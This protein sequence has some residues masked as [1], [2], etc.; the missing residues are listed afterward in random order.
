V[1]Y[2]CVLL[3]L[4][5]RAATYSGLDCDNG[6]DGSLYGDN[7]ADYSLDGD[8]G[9]HVSLNTSQNVQTNTSSR[10]ES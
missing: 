10:D 5:L 4:L 1:Y 8:N 6:A 9:V 2:D 3:L 7:G